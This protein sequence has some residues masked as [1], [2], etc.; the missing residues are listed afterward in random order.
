MT[1][2]RRKLGRRCQLLG[3]GE[4]AQAARGL[5]EVLGMWQEQGQALAWKCA[6]WEPPRCV[7]SVL[8]DDLCPGSVV[9]FSQ[10]VLPTS[11]LGA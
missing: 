8:P 1:L 5:S 11:C 9:S 3:A 10:M 2:P 6:Q 7:L 4:G